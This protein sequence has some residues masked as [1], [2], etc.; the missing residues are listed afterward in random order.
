MKFLRILFVLFGLIML[1][2][3]IQYLLVPNYGMLKEK[4]ALAEQNWYILTLIVH[5]FSGA[6]ATILGAIQFMPSIRTKSIKFHRGVGVLYTLF[7]VTGS[8]SGLLM[9][10]EA[11]GGW[12][13]T[14]GFSLLALFW[15]FSSMSAAIFGYKGKKSIHYR[16]VLISYGLTLSALILR[17]YLLISVGILKFDPILSYIV[18]AWICWVPNLGIAYLLGLKSV[19]Q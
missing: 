2:M 13:S 16:M 19:K 11:T 15:L 9:A 14:L 10:Q 4:G 1:V 5:A 12:L 3:A 8:L 6:M 17:I 18:I 7:C